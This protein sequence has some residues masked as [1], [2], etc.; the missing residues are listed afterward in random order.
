MFNN[1][2]E[3]QVACPRCKSENIFIGMSL[4]IKPNDTIKCNDCSYS[5]LAQR[6]KDQWKIQNTKRTKEKK[7]N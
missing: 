3:V 4:N 5:Q 6:F 1:Q 2:T 7:L